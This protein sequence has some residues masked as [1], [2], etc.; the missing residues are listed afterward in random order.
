MR[1]SHFLLS[2]MDAI[3]LDSLGNTYCTFYY[4]RVELVLHEMI[5]MNRLTIFLHLLLLT[6]VSNRL[7][8]QNGVYNFSKIDVKNGLSDD[9]VNAIYRDSTGFIWVGTDDGLNRCDGYGCRI[10]SINSNNHESSVDNY[11]TEIFGFPGNKIWV[12]KSG[13]TAYIYNPVTEKFDNNFGKYLKALGLPEE[14]PVNIYQDRRNN[15][16]FLYEGKGLYIY[17]SSTTKTQRLALGSKDAINS[18]ITSFS[19]DKKGNIWL[20]YANGLLVKIDR[21]SFSVL[22][23]SPLLGSAANGRLFNF[24]IFVDDSGDIWAYL[25]GET[26]GVYL[27]RSDSK[28]VI[29][30]STASKTYRLNDNLIEG[31][32]QDKKGNIWIAT[33][34]GGINVVDKA[35]YQK[36]VYVV[37]NATGKG[38]LSFNSIKLLY[39]DSR[40]FIWIGTG[41]KGLN[42]I[43]QNI[44]QFELYQHQPDRKDGLQYNDINCFAEDKKGNLWIGTN[45]GGL[46]YFDR[47]RKKFTQFLND[48]GN[49]NSVAGNIIVS[50][51]LDYNGKLW[52]G[53]YLKGMD[54]YDGKTFKHYKNK[55]S[56]PNSLSDDRV[57][58]I[59]EDSDHTLWIG[60]MKGGLNRFYP[61]S[62]KFMTYSP[63]S[64]NIP[65][66]LSTYV[67]AVRKDSEG[68]L[69]LATS[70]GVEVFDKEKMAL[71]TY[72]QAD[73]ANSLTNNTVV[74]IHEDKRGL[75]W[76]ATK[77][78]LNVFNKKTKSFQRFTTDNGLPG[79]NIQS[80]TEDEH[81]NLLIA[82]S[83]GISN[84]I[85][86]NYR[87][88]IS[89]LVKNF[90]ESNNLQGRVFNDRAGLLLRDGK[91]AIGGPMGFNILN[92]DSVA[93]DHKNASL[94]FTR[95]DVFANEI[96][97]NQPINDNI[98][99]RKSLPFTDQIVL[100]HNE[101]VFTLEFAALNFLQSSQYAYKLDGYDESWVYANSEY[102]RAR[103]SNIEPLVILQQ[104]SM[105]NNYLDF[106]SAL[107]SHSSLLTP[108]SAFYPICSVHTLPAAAFPYSCAV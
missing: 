71:T 29:N 10:F 40:G 1:F 33:D 55:P 43:N 91:I 65:Q 108:E 78:G 63:T 74:D 106:A 107:P 6:L 30:F 94:I 42:Y 12:G 50:L 96:N 52:I 100:N 54:V 16:W 59:M 101:N 80:I 72:Q 69:W 46:I 14:K 105:L 34:H 17:N 8:A 70:K 85:I 53:T 89:F 68:N 38:S 87:G 51:C 9:H 13:N 45:G 104:D 11:V 47:L 92:L 25:R 19:E 3:K 90:S 102:R 44:H 82:T 18:T 103:Y 48:T 77:Y 81:G 98:I 4:L 76:V 36:I 22:Q 73:N 21:Q 75:V 95:I 15:Y 2:L 97:V 64:K 61:G 35:N 57:W 41:K 20:A 84:L 28:K 24:K 27:V 58:S 62:Q 56:D 99:L 7:A 86:Q 23:K 66:I 67:A 26:R 31:I 5:K 37:N 88:K 32:T 83:R 93:A 49:E 60:T 39:N 79:N